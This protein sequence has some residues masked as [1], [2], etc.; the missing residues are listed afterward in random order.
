[1][2]IGLISVMQKE[3]SLKVR[4]LLCMM[5]SGP[6]GSQPLMNPFADPRLWAKLENDSRTKEFVKDPD[7]RQIIEKLQKQ[8]SELG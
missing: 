4:C 6:A 2:Y 5:Y 7:Y 8:P 3:I 1:M